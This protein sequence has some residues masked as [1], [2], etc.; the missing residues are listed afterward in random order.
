MNRIELVL[1]GIKVLK[2][3]V[4]NNGSLK[5]GSWGICVIFEELWLPLYTVPEIEPSIFFT[6]L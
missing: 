2:P 5:Q 6:V 4:L 3:V 1:G